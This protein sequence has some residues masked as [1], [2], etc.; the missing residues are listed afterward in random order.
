VVVRLLLVVVRLLGGLLVVALLGVLLVAVLLLVLVLGLLRGHVVGRG[1]GRI[2]LRLVRAVRLAESQ[3]RNTGDEQR[4]SERRSNCGP[5]A[6]HEIP[7]CHW[8]LVHNFVVG[9]PRPLRL[10]A[11]DRPPQQRPDGLSPPTRR[12]TGGRDMSLWPCDPPPALDVSGPLP[13][14]ASYPKR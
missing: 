13:M 2:G 5:S 4:T 11:S 3:G 1:G 7:F 9:H 8:G 14:G 12:T 6:P 10:R